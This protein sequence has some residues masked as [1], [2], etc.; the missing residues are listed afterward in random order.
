VFAAGLGEAEKA[1]IAERQRRDW[2]AMGRQRHEAQ[3][4]ERE[5]RISGQ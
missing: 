4:G 5:V 2:E 3:P 1:R